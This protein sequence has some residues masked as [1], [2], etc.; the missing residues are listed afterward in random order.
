MIDFRISVIIRDNCPAAQ[1]SFLASL[2]AMNPGL[3][4]PIKSPTSFWGTMIEFGCGAGLKV[5][6]PTEF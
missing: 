5:G 1:I 6:G 2:N 4:W 3:F